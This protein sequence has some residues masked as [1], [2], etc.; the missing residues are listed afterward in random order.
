M[1]NKYTADAFFAGVGG[2]EKGFTKTGLVNVLYANEFDK[3]A[4]I[5]YKLNNPSVKFDNRDVHQVTGSDLPDSELMIGGFPCF[6]KDAL[7]QTETGF[8]HINE[9]KAGDLVL[10]RE[11][12]FKPVV[13][14]MQKHA[15]QLYELRPEGELPVYA[16]GNHPILA[17][18]RISVWNPQR[19]SYEK[20][21]AEPRWVAAKDLRKG[22][23]VLVNPYK[24]NTSLNLS[25]ADIWLL[26]RYIADG[27]CDK[28]AVIFRISRNKQDEFKK[29]LGAHR[30]IFSYDKDNPDCIKY[31]ITSMRLLNLVKQVH[32]DAY[33]KEIPPFVF[34]LPKR[35]RK[36]FIDGFCAGSGIN[37]NKSYEY[38][39]MTV[40]PK[41]AVGLSALI[42][43]TE[44]QEVTDTRIVN[45][46]GAYKLSWSNKPAKFAHAKIIDGEFW[47]PIKIVKKVDKPAP[48]YNLEVKDSHTYTVNGYTVHN[49]QAFSLA[50]YQKGFKD[51]RGTLF[52]EM[53]RLV[54]IKRPRVVFFENVKNLVGH[55]K[56]NTFKVIVE[57][58]VKNG[59]SVKW[60]VMNACEYGNLSQNRERTY[61]V[62][63]RNKADFDR[64]SFPGK[65]KLTKSVRD[66]IDFAKAV[67]S[68]Y[69]YTSSNFAHFDELNRAMTNPDHIY[70]WRRVYVRENK[71]GL[72]PTLTASMGMGGHNVPLIRTNDGRIRKLTPRECFNVQGYDK[73]F[74]LP[75]ISNGQLYKQAGNSVAV[76]VIK[77]IADC[78]IKA[79]DTPDLP[80]AVNNQKY[81]LLRYKLNSKYDGS[82]YLAATDSDKAKLVKSDTVNERDYFKLIKRNKPCEFSIVERN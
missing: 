57:A 24:T 13:K 32:K 78:V 50:G 68:K 54:K 40:S 37:T 31:V 49:C 76:P 46:H 8:K 58:L 66:V 47:K 38:A 20:V 61:L 21:V 26:G 81:V 69:Y 30:A 53:L 22:D 14:T 19:K 27:D 55:D 59:Y 48:V 36:I 41:L 34:T 5:T 62:A 67:D 9:V 16:T 25:D 82:C 1:Q 74:K 18:R 23:L 60:K 10:T 42:E 12:D 71:S 56:G 65:I 77:R 43:L 17:R 80:K 33:N 52:F 73:S 7:V 2:I 72:V 3:N 29:H 11:G 63:F 75:K 79:I 51:P 15:S 64:F 6:T 39:Y 35:L 4:G 44:H 45:Q 28:H 70:Q